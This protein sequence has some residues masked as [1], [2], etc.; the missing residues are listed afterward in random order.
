MTDK[1]FEC[2]V[3]G[4]E[5]N[6]NWWAVKKYKEPNGDIVEFITCPKDGSPALIIDDRD[7]A[8]IGEAIIGEAVI[9]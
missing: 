4:K 2:K 8:I 6:Y 7:N 1:K 5:Y 3:C 9:E